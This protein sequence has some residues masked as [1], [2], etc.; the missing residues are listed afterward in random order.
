[1]IHPIGSARETQHGTRSRG[2][3][4]AALDHRGLAGRAAHERTSLE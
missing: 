2:K 3:E 1:M 4:I